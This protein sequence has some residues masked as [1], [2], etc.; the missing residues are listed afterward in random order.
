MVKNLIFKVLIVSGLL[1]FVK[2]TFS[3]DLTQFSFHAINVDSSKFVGNGIFT[4]TFSK[5]VTFDI[6]IKSQATTGI[7]EQLETKISGES[8]ANKTQNIVWNGKSK[9]NEAFVNNMQLN[10][11]ISITSNSGVSVI[12]YALPYEA[13]LD[14]D[15]DK[16]F[17]IVDTDAD[18]DGIPAWVEYNSNR[19][20]EDHDNDFVP[21]FLDV[22]FIDKSGAV[23]IDF[24]SDGINDLF[25]A[26]KD[27]MLNDLDLDANNDG[28][29]DVWHLDST[30]GILRMQPKS[31]VDQNGNGF[32]D[33]KENSDWVAQDFD[34][35]GIFDFLDIDADNDGLSNNLECQDISDIRLA[36]GFDVN[37]NGVLD[38]YDPRMQNSGL[39]PGDGN[40]NG[41]PDFLELN[42]DG[43]NFHDNIC[44][45][46]FVI[47]RSSEFSGC[48]SSSGSMNCVTIAV[49]NEPVPEEK[50]V[51]MQWDMGDLNLVEG[52]SIKHC[53]EQ[54]GYYQVRLNIL[55]ANDK[56]LIQ[57]EEVQVKAATLS[58]YSVSVV[59]KKEA[60]VNE[61]IDLSLGA[62][63]MPGY[64][65]EE[66][67]WDFGDGTY[68]CGYNQ[69]HL[70]PSAGNYTVKVFVRIKGDRTYH[71]ICNQKEIK[72]VR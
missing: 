28:L 40:K 5:D 25:D 29:F 4:M 37:N 67:Y 20:Y 39:L 53:Y 16:K 54:P 47:K 3:Q 41:I 44:N 18:N 33:S 71:Y 22:D 42:R 57:S 63:I 7:S 46:E 2:V 31:F 65:F 13:K 10:V 48:A 24:N 30:L 64:Y 15:K 8:V 43:I 51:I 49:E 45:A 72:I 14:Y 52:R 61:M 60:R 50:E 69:Q 21:N 19:P 36:Y 11:K 35:D 56:A 23:F 38:I 12:N 70:Y 66:V 55:D 62:V 34:R 9:S 6:L 1:V 17:N 58:G 26:D 59:S 32:E 27:G 68:T